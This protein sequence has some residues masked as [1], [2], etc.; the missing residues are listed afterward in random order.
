MDANPRIGGSIEGE[1]NFLVRSL[2]AI[3]V[4]RADSLWWAVAGASGL[5]DQSS[6]DVLDSRKISPRKLRNE[7]THP[8]G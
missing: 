4:H 8:G 1:G 2:E 7:G 6:Q 5:L 3:I